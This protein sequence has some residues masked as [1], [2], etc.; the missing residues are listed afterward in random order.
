MNTRL[1]DA[2][3]KSLPAAI[4][5][6]SPVAGGCIN[7]AWLVHLVD[8]T[9]IFVKSNSR[10]QPRFF[11]VEADGLDWLRDGLA[12]GAGDG[13]AVPEVVAWSDADP[14]FLA[15]G[16]VD[17]RSGVA[18]GTGGRPDDDLFGAALARL[19]Q[20]AAPSFGWEHDGYIGDWPQPNA[21]AT[22]WSTFL[23]DERLAPLAHTAIDRGALPLSAGQ[24]FSRLFDRLADLVGP[25]EPPARLH[26]DLWSGNRLVDAGHRSWLV[27]PAPYGGHR[28]VDLAMMRLF[29]G[30]G[31]R[32]FAAYDE[33]FP[34]ASGH[35][36]R[37]ALYQLYPL[38]V[39][40]VLFGAAY[41]RR[42]LDALD[43]YA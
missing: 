11:G 5:S 21:A 12:G 6:T 36:E 7:E 4:S 33:A 15:L 31:E 35:E 23:R 18:T 16:W 39:H 13:I 14:A 22:D 43:R 9:R 10:P 27:D 32:A 8:G 1:V 38:L 30:F 40:V 19:H 25:A 20:T 34:L 28:E 2:L 26:G 3:S 29:G 17:V 41:S 24:R 37:V 42:T